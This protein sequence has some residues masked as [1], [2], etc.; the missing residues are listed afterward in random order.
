MPLGSPDS[1]RNL[2][3]DVYQGGDTTELDE[4]EDG[5]RERE[6]SAST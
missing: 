3:E 5:E 1:P 2:C 4:E 6:F